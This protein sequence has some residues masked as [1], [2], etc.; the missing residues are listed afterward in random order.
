MSD[1][2][3]SRGAPDE[4]RLGAL[5]AG[6][7]PTLGPKFYRRMATAPWRA[8]GQA[9]PL[10]RRPRW[11]AVAVTLLVAVLLTTSVVGY[12]L[13]PQYY[14]QL[15]ALTD[16]PRLEYG[17]GPVRSFAWNGAPPGQQLWAAVPDAMHVAPGGPPA[18]GQAGG[19]WAALSAEQPGKAIVS[20]T[21][22]EGLGLVPPYNQPPGDMF[23]QNYGTNP[24]V[25]TAGDNLSTFGLD[26]DTASYSLI[27]SYLVQG[28]LPPPDAVRVE[29]VVNY[30]NPRYAAPSDTA[31]AIY[32]EGAPSAFGAPNQ[33][34]LRVGLQGRTI[35]VAQRQD[36]VLTFVVDT[37]GSMADGSRLE[38]VKHALRLL[39]DQLRPSDVVAIVAYSTSARVVLQ[40]TGGAERATIL[41]AIET[42]HPQESTNAEAG[43]VLGYQLAAGAFREGASNRV[44]LAS[45]G[46]ANVGNT[47]AGGILETIANSAARGITLSAIGV[48]MG[49]YNDVLLEQ[50][51]DKGDGN[52]AYVDTPDEAQRIFVANLTG[53]LQV[54]ARDAK[55]QL[56]FNPKV[57]ARYRL[58]GYENRAVADQ[59][60][61]DDAVD[62]GE[63][64]AGHHV[65]ALYE[66][67][68]V[69]GAGGDALVVHLRYQD[70]AGGQI[71]ELAQPFARE[72]FWP[73]F[74][75]ASPEFRLSAAAAQYAEILR[76]STYAQGESMGAV[77]PVLWR[78]QQELFFDPEVAA[79][80][81][82]VEKASGLLGNRYDGPNP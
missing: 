8:D 37:S 35:E 74:D 82:L 73:S 61:R 56:E 7:Q 67:E 46:V 43:L 27:R 71:V 64:G 40:P 44:V 58:L 9:L 39:V 23:F 52:Y 70:A 11:A 20:L 15:T 34:L 12:P 45:D 77:L 14:G 22:R 4:E 55:L 60:F 68:L 17:A 21:T 31:M 36:A 79:F 47:T 53:T 76:G 29:E 2:D 51:A 26:V 24:F 75:A 10:R 57:V 80:T 78:V 54:I 59:Q 81:Q 6:F 48:G 65:T 13:R 62:A 38:L 69:E 16:S 5:L 41:A 50:L 30:F 19:E 18:A 42:L 25:D 28:Y 1:R 66:L 49:N 63:V 33:V 3:D 32:L 72:S